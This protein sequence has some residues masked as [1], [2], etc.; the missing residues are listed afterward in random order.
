MIESEA[1]PDTNIALISAEF[2][3]A[4]YAELRTYSGDAKSALVLAPGIAGLFSRDA[5]D[6][7]SLDNGGTIIRDGLGRRWKRI[8]QGA[9]V[10]P[11]WFGAKWDGV[12]DDAPALNA[13]HA[14][15]S[16][17]FYPPGTTRVAFTV[18]VNGKA[19]AIMGSGLGVTKVLLDHHYDGIRFFGDSTNYSEGIFVKDISI[20]RANPNSYTDVIGPKSLLIRY[21]TRPVIER[22]EETGA[23]GFGLQFWN[24]HYPSALSCYVHDHKGGSTGP[25]GTDG[26]H[27]YVCTFCRAWG[28][29]VERVGDDAISFGSFDATK[30]TTD[31]SVMNNIV[32]DTGGG[33]IKHYAYVSR[34]VISGNVISKVTNGGIYLT[35]DANSPANSV[36]EDVQISNNEFLECSGVA[37]NF[38]GGMI[39]LRMWPGSTNAVMQNI[40]INGNTGRNC[41]S[42]IIALSYGPTKR[43]KDISIDNFTFLDA[44]VGI[45]GGDNDAIRFIQ[46]DGQLSIRNVLIRGATSNG[47]A[48]NQVHASYAASWDDTV[49]TMSNILIDGYGKGVT[50]GPSARG[51]L[52]RP[53]T[54]RLTLNMDSIDVRGQHLPEGATPQEAIQVADLHPLSNINN[55]SFDHSGTRM[56]FGA[57]AAYRGN[58]AI[59][60]SQPSAGTHYSGKTVRSTNY[61]TGTPQGWTCVSSGTYGSLYATDGTSAVTGSMTAGSRILTVSDATNL[62]RGT[63][64]Q[65]AGAGAGAGVLA[66][67]VAINGNV[68]TLSATAANNV[69]GATVSF[70]TPGW[71]ALP[72]WV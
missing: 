18:S 3:A 57:N 32:R 52:S 6:S 42:G 33:G 25:T 65:V 55:V 41:R 54:K 40:S 31:I 30:P 58:N 60:A 53:A 67:V 35:D 15:H 47:I 69:T 20:I 71:S 16:V 72:N 49:V 39:R 37:G 46:C 56:F 24:C 12:T 1:Q 21:A 64:I 38:E 19:T 36:V 63:V 4:D 48:L 7:T 22:V 59:A 43:F 23:I 66:V 17:V 70:V 8:Y 13:A 2:E 28:N 68:A 11:R 26:I 5:S 14:A 44:A 45:I 29:V 51:I 62:S 9:A 27:F 10:D 34:S 50:A 61:A